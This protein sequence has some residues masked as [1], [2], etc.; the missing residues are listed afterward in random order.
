MALGL[1]AVPLHS[2]H[3]DANNRYFCYMKMNNNDLVALT[4]IKLYFLDPPVS[5]RLH[6]HAVQKIDE[7]LVIL[8][9][10]D[11][12]DAEVIGYLQDIKQEIAEKSPSLP[13]LRAE[14]IKAGQMIGNLNN[15]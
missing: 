6:K 5:F 2:K 11:L 7:C 12:R 3:C 14:L 1:R 13:Q 8:S 4:E 10:Y 15:R 9:H